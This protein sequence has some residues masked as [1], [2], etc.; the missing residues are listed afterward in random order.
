[1]NDA[2]VKIPVERIEKAIYIIRGEKV[3]LDRDLAE[4]YGVE[5][6]VLKQAVRRNLTRFPDDFMF[7]LAKD[8]FENWRS[9]FVTSNQDRLGLRHAPMAFTEQGVAMLSTVLRSKQAIS[10]NVEIMRTFVRL[11]T[12]LFSNAELANKLNAL[13]KK[14]DAQFKIVFDAIKKLMMPPDKPKGGIGFINKK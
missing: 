12:M 3:M 11:R 14:Y 6:R 8:E 1:M 13:E 10:V 4:L 9:Q 5:T 7:V 2:L